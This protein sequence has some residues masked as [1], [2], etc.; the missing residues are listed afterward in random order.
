MK[1]THNFGVAKFIFSTN[2]NH[3]ISR[4]STLTIMLTSS[5]RQ[6]LGISPQTASKKRLLDDF[7]TCGEL[8]QGRDHPNLTFI[9][10]CRNVMSHP[11]TIVDCMHKLDRDCLS[12]WWKQCVTNDT[13]TY[14]PTHPRLEVLA[15]Q[16]A[17]FLL[18]KRHTTLCSKE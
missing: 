15:A 5:D 18:P 12:E 2:S 8:V 7:V 10:I 3:V 4:H 17:R 1:V 11:Y 16:Y 13:A 14:Q 9:A 6:S